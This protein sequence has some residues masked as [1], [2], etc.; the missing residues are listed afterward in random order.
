M[1]YIDTTLL[2]AMT[3]QNQISYNYYGIDINATNCFFDLSNGLT[4]TISS[5]SANTPPSGCSGLQVKNYI[6]TS[7]SNLFYP[8]KSY[9]F[10]SNELFIISPIHNILNV[11]VDAKGKPMNGVVAELIIKHTPVTGKNVVYTCFYL[12]YNFSVT[13]SISENDVDEII[14]FFQKNRASGSVSPT[15]V[16]ANSIPIQNKGIQYN[17]SAGD[18]VFIF[19]N[20]IQINQGSSSYLTNLVPFANLPADLVLK[21]IPSNKTPKDALLMKNNNIFISAEDKI[22]ISCKPTGASD[23][24]IKTYNVPI[25]SE[26]TANAAKID[27]MATLVQLSFVFTIL[28][29][30]YFSL[31]RVYKWAVIDNVNKFVLNGDDKSPPNNRTKASMD[32]FAKALDLGDKLDNGFDTLIRIATI[33]VL[34]SVFVLF[35]FISIIISSSANG[36]DPGSI[37][38]IV[39]LVIIYMAGFITIYYNKR[40]KEFM[41]TKISSNDKSKPEATEGFEYVDKIGKEDVWSFFN[42]SDLIL[43]FSDIMKFIG[44][45]KWFTVFIAVSVVML[46]IVIGIIAAVNKNMLSGNPGGAAVGII[47]G[48]IGYVFGFAAIRMIR[49]TRDDYNE[50]GTS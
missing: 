49:M 50:M 9:T 18:N 6:P 5:N 31:P 17:N 22:Y 15:P 23:D 48:L 1:S 38:A 35:L 14:N 20:P 41:Q 7:S 33:D 46:G 3:G 28:I 29:V 32:L 25:I 47:F 27:A 43:F 26:Y 45:D 42:A 36:F 37:I 24:E 13:A 30:S 39:Y 44:K 34:I 12:S 10:A 2:G 19:T 8:N 16:L 21:P 11:N 4:A 40:F